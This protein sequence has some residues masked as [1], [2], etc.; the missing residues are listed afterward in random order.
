MSICSVITCQEREKD[1][2]LRIVVN[3]KN[4]MTLKELRKR[5]SKILGKMGKK[6]QENASSFL[7]ER[8]PKIKRLQEGPHMSK[9]DDRIQLRQHSTLMVHDEFKHVIAN[10]FDNVNSSTTRR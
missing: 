8:V 9:A 1:L 2:R 6:S 5:R 7:D 3:T 4:D 10:Y